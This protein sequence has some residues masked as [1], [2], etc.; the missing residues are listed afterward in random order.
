MSSVCGRIL[1][2]PTTVNNGQ[3]TSD[4]AGGLPRNQRGF[5]VSPRFAKSGAWLHTLQY[6]LPGARDVQLAEKTLP[7]NVAAWHC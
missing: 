7:T 1:G 4:C 2:A 3:N 6:A 5:L